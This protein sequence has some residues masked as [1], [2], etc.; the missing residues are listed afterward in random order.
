[1]DEAWSSSFS[2]SSEHRRRNC[3]LASNGKFRVQVLA[4]HLPPKG[5]TLN[6]LSSL[7]RE[8]RCYSPT[9]RTNIVRPSRS[10]FENKGRWR[11]SMTSIT[12]QLTLVLLIGLAF[13][14]RAGD[15]ATARAEKVGMS[16]E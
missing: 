4:C 14:A 16:S 5:G 1:M 7:S 6:L 11:G 13:P 15:L 8:R 9:V 2:S 12:R 10:R 3:K